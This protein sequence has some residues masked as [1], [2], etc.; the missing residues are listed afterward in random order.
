[1]KKVLM[2]AAALSIVAT[3][4]N[5]SPL[6]D[7]Q[8]A[9]SAAAGAYSELGGNIHGSTG[10]T[11]FNTLLNNIEDRVQLGG[12]EN[13]CFVFMG[14]NVCRDV[15]LPPQG[16]VA[17]DAVVT[18]ATTAANSVSADFVGSDGLGATGT[19]V[20]D[21][22][23]RIVAA[24]TVYSTAVSGTSVTGAQARAAY[25]AFVAV[26]DDET[27]SISS[28]STGVTN[29]S[30]TFQSSNQT[31][32]LAAA[33]EVQNSRSISTHTHADD[34]ALSYSSRL[35]RL[36]ND[37]TTVEVPA[38]VSTQHPDLSR[39]MIPT[40]WTVDSYNSTTG[41][42]VLNA[43]ASNAATNVSIS[44]DG[45]GTA[46]LRTAAIKTAVNALR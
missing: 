5:A 46:A 44:L 28:A 4:A 33:F 10:G 22:V 27:A 19:L 2:T 11:A 37:F 18:S 20:G 7:A 25:D 26:Y 39:V 3:A 8:A 24:G 40:G 42:L 12:V 32:F 17:I 13:R 9:Y 16:N 31:A 15:P 41:A 29:F 21:A 1:M 38:Q 6:A 36:A 43:G 45:Q 14:R 34:V 35:N 30:D 23:D